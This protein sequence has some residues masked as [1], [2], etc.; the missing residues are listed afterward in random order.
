MNIKKL[1]TLLLFSSGL[2]TSSLY[3]GPDGNQL[4]DLN[5]AACHGS[6]GSGSIGAR[7]ST[8]PLSTM[9]DRYLFNTI[10]NGRP[11]RIM[12]DFNNLS[13]SQV[14]SLVAYLREFTNTQDI[15]LD[16][17]SAQVDPDRGK[18]LYQQNCLGCHG[19]DGK[20]VGDGTGVAISR[21]RDHTYIPPAL[22]NQGFLASADD[23]Q[24]R[25]F[26]RVG[27][28]NLNMPAFAKILTTDE[29]N[30]VVAYIRSF[31]SNNDVVA[32]ISDE[33]EQNN[34]SPSLFFDSPYDFQT[35]IKNLK[36]ALVGANFRT[37]PDRYLEQGLFDDNDVNKHHLTIRFCNFAY[38]YQML[39]IE[40][41]LGMF[42]P[43]RITVIENLDGS[44]QL[45]AMNLMKIR[46]FFNNEQLKEFAEQMQ[47]NQLD[48]IEEATL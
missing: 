26:I 8:I 33:K 34:D 42:L 17:Y 10:R 23:K 41:R 25:H 29:I 2:L 39:N 19:E 11:G 47:Q 45:I 46:E 24:I 1:I 15:F 36:Q 6:D 22:N 35:T 5:C 30:D 43:C 38:L 27:N 9:T 44:V 12:P 40:P 13:D 16:D 31:E 21:E 37:F 3:A 18:S 7:L 28:K 20:S 32:S 4:F 14:N 48:I